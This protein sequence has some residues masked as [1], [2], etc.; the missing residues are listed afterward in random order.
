MWRFILVLGLMAATAASQRLDNA[1]AVNTERA[2]GDD[3][4]RLRKLPDVFRSKRSALPTCHNAFERRYLCPPASVIEWCK[5]KRCEDAL[6][7][8]DVDH[9]RDENG[10]CMYTGVCHT[11]HAGTYL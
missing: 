10:R 1:L 9:E 11:S 7:D 2:T 6:C 8:C 3:A 4:S 5:T